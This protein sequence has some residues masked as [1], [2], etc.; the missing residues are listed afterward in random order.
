M[1]A[2]YVQFSK[3]NW[4]ASIHKVSLVR[5]SNNVCQY[6]D[7]RYIERVCNQVQ[8]RKCR[9][10][11]QDCRL[12]KIR[13]V[14]TKFRVPWIIAHRPSTFRWDK[15]CSWIGSGTQTKRSCIVKLNLRWVFVMC[16][17][18]CAVLVLRC[19]GVPKSP[20]GW[21]LILKV[22]LMADVV[23]QFWV[24]CSVWFAKMSTVLGVKNMVLLLHLQDRN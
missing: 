6:L 3:N 7:T 22:S 18:C 14:D 24:H 12:W 5:F 1:G 21:S 23:S 2:H 20:K 4:K 16:V 15:M 10:Y 13:G 19:S 8:Q 11:S 17:L 9:K